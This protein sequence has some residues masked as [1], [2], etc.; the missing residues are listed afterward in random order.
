MA[1]TEY[2]EDLLI[3]QPAIELFG[4]LDYETA[5]CFHE[6]FGL[7][8]TLGREN[9]GEVVLVSRLRPVLEKFN[10]ELPSEAITQAVEELANDRSALHPVLANKD[11]YKMLKDGVRVSFRN[12][13]GD[14][15][16]EYVKVIDWNSP[17]NNDFFLA[18]QFWV[19][20]EIYKKRADL[21]GFVNGLPL[22]LV[23]LK[24]SHVRLENAYRD[25]LYDYKQTIPQLFWYNNLIILSNGNDTRVG[26]ISSAWEHFNEW[27]KINNFFKV[28]FSGSKIIFPV[29]DK[30]QPV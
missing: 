4:E 1:P 6:A 25:N 9:P 7:F 21:V 24:A 2:S 8:G 10:P 19:T 18:S 15:V 28:F 13:D 20:G 14:E 3:E 17:D 22:I 23:E 11:V 29:I 30:P 12:E 5:N 16:V 26:T 27:K